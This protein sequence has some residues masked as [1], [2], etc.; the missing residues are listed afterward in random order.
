MRYGMIP[1][2]LAER[3]AVW[4]G[5]VPVGVADVFSPLVQTRS[6][7]AAVQFGIA[8]AIGTRK[9]SAVD[10]A[11]SCNLDETA[12]DMLLRV[13]VAS[14]Y[15]SASNG[16]SRKLAASLHLAS[17]D[18]DHFANIHGP[19]GRFPAPAGRMGAGCGP[20]SSWR[21]PLGDNR[22]QM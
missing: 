13:L 22:T 5:C 8:D 16:S 19:V 6:L 18:S 21:E 2:R 15:L 3:L 14:G 17:R 1:T 11:R 10:V 20:Q 12:L 4:F 9:V 7:M